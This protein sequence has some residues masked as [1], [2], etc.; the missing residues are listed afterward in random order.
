MSS[1]K[2]P[3]N[4]RNRLDRLHK[5]KAA[6]QWLSR[7]PQPRRRKRKENSAI[8][9]RSKNRGVIQ[10]RPI[11]PVVQRR[12]ITPLAFQDLKRQRSGGKLEHTV[13]SPVIGNGPR[14]H[15]KMRGK[16]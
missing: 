10:R 14:V 11:P 5:R 7:T 1:S 4:L 13:S 3:R 2:S 8:I 16:N 6:K 15:R 9:T 12:T